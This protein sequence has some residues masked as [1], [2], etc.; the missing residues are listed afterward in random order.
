MSTSQAAPL[1]GQLHD[2]SGLVFGRLTV[3]GCVGRQGRWV[4]WLCRCDCGNEFKVRG[5]ALTRASNN[6]RACR[7]CCRKT[8]GQSKTELHK[9]W[10]AMRHRC[11]NPNHDSYQEYGGRGISVCDRWNSFELFAADVGPR[12]STKHTLDR[13]NNDGDYEPSNVR[14]A[15]PS[16][17]QRNQRHRRRYVHK[18]ESLL[19][20]EWSERTGIPRS[21]LSNRIYEGWPL[22]EALTIPHIRQRRLTPQERKLHIAARGFVDREIKAGRLSRPE[23]CEFCGSNKS[24]ITAHHHKGYRRKHWADVRWCCLPCNRRQEAFTANQ[25]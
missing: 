22:S 15:T 20:S 2:L 24:I 3:T 13:R 16:Q 14:W 6:T 4:F 12:P 18:C 17:Q 5:E 25:P 9:I 1:N 23:R 21:T 19:L 11:S 10:I 7:K 8:H